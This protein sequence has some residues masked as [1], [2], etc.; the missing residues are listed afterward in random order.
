MYNALLNRL[1]VVFTNSEQTSLNRCLNEL[2]LGNKPPSQLLLEMRDLSVGRLDDDS[3]KPVWL[4]RLPAH[5]QSILSPSHDNLNILAAMADKIIELLPSA[6]SSKTELEDLRA[7]MKQL[8]K[9]VD[10]LEELKARS[11][12]QLNSSSRRDKDKGIPKVSFESENHPSNARKEPLKSGMDT[13]REPAPAGEGSGH[14]SKKQRNFYSESIGGKS[15][16]EIPGIGPQMANTF[17]RNGITQAEQIIGKYMTMIGDEDK[18]IEFMME[19][20]GAIIRR[21]REVHR[22]C[23]VYCDNNIY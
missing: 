23:K 11:R 21:A 13:K 3:L 2:E 7:D 10:K 20:G 14:R 17:E 19:K 6:D 9:R 5:L 18:F 1:E 22:V 12:P 16:S 8:S 4:Q 15:V